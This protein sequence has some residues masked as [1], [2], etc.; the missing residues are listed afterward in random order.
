[1]DK[2]LA[3]LSPKPQSSNVNPSVGQEILSKLSEQQLLLE[4]QKCFLTTTTAAP[5]AHP[6]AGAVGEPS[7]AL[8]RASDGSFSLPLPVDGAQYDAQNTEV[9]ELYRL[10][11]ELFAANSKIA[12]QEQE[13]AQTRVMKHTLDQALGT[14]SEADFGGRE[15]TEQ[16]ISQL[17]NSLNASTRPFHQIQDAWNTQEDAQSDVSDALSAGAYNRARG[18]WASPP[19][20]ALALNTNVP[21]AEKGYGEP[22]SLPNSY[23]GQDSKVWSGAA[24]NPFPSSS[25]FQP[26]RVISGPSAGGCGFDSRFSGEQA[27]YL[28]GP[29]LGPRR[30]MTQANRGGSC[31]PAQ[32]SPWPA[33][34]TEPSGNAIPRSPGGMPCSTYQQV[35]LYPIPPY[36]PRPVGTP[37]SPTAT[38]F[39]S[40]SS[41]ALPWGNSSVSLLPRLPSLSVLI[42]VGWWK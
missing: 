26:H 18:F 32:S 27:R 38:E 37:L 30:S 34:P 21:P 22:L 3:K 36:Q 13:L 6:A 2:I 20:P 16:T 4:R 9:A 24:A 10:K 41:N 12:V 8:P 23:A 33:F 25:S 14:P 42:P 31:F 1:M 19:Q 35:G 5:G 29:G 40:S 28:Q 17:Q 15:V 7:N 11:E 39:T